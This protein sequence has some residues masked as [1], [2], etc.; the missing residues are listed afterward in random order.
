MHVGRILLAATLL[1]MSAALL[2]HTLLSPDG[3]NRRQ[4][5]RADLGT[6]RTENSRL[7][8]EV[9]RLR[10]QIEALRVREEVQERVIRDELGYVRPDDVNLE[11][12][13]KP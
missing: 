2:L 12:G 4:K 6:L 3:W 9:Q 5:A 13:N 10:A 7:E 1:V 11:V 8:S